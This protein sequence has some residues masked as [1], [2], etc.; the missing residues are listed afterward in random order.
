MYAAG[1]KKGKREK[2]RGKKGEAKTNK[3]DDRKKGEPTNLMGLAGERVGPE[4]REEKEK[5][6]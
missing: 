1:P 3:G 6:Q 4:T 2:K 5:K